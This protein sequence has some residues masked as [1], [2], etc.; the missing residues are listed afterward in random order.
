MMIFPDS[1]VTIC[2][3]GLKHLL[4]MG[5]TMNN[6]IPS[7][8][9]AQ[10]VGGFT[11]ICLVW[12][13]VEF[14][15]HEKTT[16]QAL[17]TCQK[18]QH[19]YFSKAACI[20]VRILPKDFPNSTATI[21]PIED[22]AMQ[23]IPLTSTHKTSDASPK[24]N[25]V[26]EQLPTRSQ[27]LPFSPTEQNIHRLKNWLLKHFAETALKNNGEFPPMSAH[28]HLKEGAVSKARHSPIPVPIPLKEPVRQAL[29]ENVK[30]G[31][32]T[33]VPVSMPIDWCSTMVITAKKNGKP[34]RTIEYKHLNS[35]CKQETHYTGSPFQLALQVPPKQKKT[36]LDAVDG[37]HSI[38][39]D[40]DSQPL[41]TFITEW[42]RFMYLRMTQ[43][44]LAFGDT[45]TRR[46]D[47][48]TKD[49]PCKVEI[50][51]DTLLYDSSIEEAFY[52]TFD[53]LL[54]CAKNGIALNREKFQFCQDIVQFGGLQIIPSGV[55]PSK[56]IL[57]VILSFPI[58]KTLTD[59][60]SWFGLVNQ[61]AWAYSLGPV[62]LPF[63]NVIK[64]ESHFIWNKSFKDAFKH[65]KKVIVNLVRKGIRFTIQH[66][67]GKWP[68]A[69]D[70][71]SCNPA[72]ILQALLNVFPAE[73]FW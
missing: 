37:Y 68:R 6:L 9:V 34:R 11:L 66:C 30:K 12:L 55:I 32:V 51:D 36:V 72:T 26:E 13:P 29:W 46:Y 71:I 65:S 19:L 47:E 48:I 31:I 4:N 25:R 69:S 45:Y 38:L 27:K 61:V 43:G 67:P 24:H 44:Y 42:E 35:Q 14:I 16:K 64:R 7:R 15:V 53:F 22:M 3:G 62:M 59:A 2:I 54:H 60:R 50:V 70:A 23:C 33:P 28:I 49:I 1:G 17:N 20:D 8:K 58:P 39:L 52:H 40:K 5:L 73:P 21:P 10:A 63:R 57:G 41:T 18:I 56:S